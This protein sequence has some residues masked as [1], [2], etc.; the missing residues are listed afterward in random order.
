MYEAMDLFHQHAPEIEK[1]IFFSAANLFNLELDLIFYD[2]TTASFSIDYED[3]TNDDIEP[4]R[5]YG[6]SKEGI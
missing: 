1:Q 3:Q 5:K 6:H 4:L 2:T